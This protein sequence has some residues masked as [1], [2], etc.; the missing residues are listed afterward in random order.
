MDLS[1]FAVTPSANKQ[2]PISA[3][4]LDQ[5]RNK[6]EVKS[7]VSKDR[8][9]ASVVVLLGK[10]AIALQIPTKEEATH[11]EIDHTDGGAALLALVEKVKR[12][13]YSGGF[14]NALLAE[15]ERI[16][17]SRADKKI[18]EQDSSEANQ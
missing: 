7:T 6:A 2:T 8:K 4:T 12:I 3:M 18:K 15:Q 1:V 11:L 13:L 9:T 10:P 16:R 14:D 5:L 17:K